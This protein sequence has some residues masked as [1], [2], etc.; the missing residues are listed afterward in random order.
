MMKER[1]AHHIDEDAID[2][3]REIEDIDDCEITLLPGEHT[4]VEEEVDT[5]ANNVIILV[6]V[7]SP[8]LFTALPFFDGCYVSYFIDIFDFLL[9]ADPIN[10]MG[11]HTY[12]SRF[13]PQGSYVMHKKL[14]ELENGGWKL[15][16]EFKQFL[17]AVKGVSK[18]V[19]LQ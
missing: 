18:S 16:P 2:K 14:E 12:L 15:K 3:K 11:T 8:T 5:E 19:G 4:D 17:A 7:D 13:M 9:H 10:G 6:P 1:V